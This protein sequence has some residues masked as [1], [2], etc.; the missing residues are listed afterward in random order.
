MTADS[1]LDL[2]AAEML[3]FTPDQIRARK[4]VLSATGISLILLSTEILLV[5][6]EHSAAFRILLSGSGA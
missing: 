2:S 3:A 4:Q 1:N 6:Y 5:A